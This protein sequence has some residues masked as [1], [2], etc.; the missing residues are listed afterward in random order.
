MER[1]AIYLILAVLVVFAVLA[2]KWVVWKLQHII[3]SNGI[4]FGTLLVLVII[5]VLSSLIVTPIIA[6]LGA[7]IS[8]GY[9]M[10]I[11]YISKLSLPAAILLSAFI[12]GIGAHLAFRV[13]NE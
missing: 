2:Y 3:R 6:F 1:T 11:I 8:A 5:L 7:L 9:S 4:I 10:L 13:S 12:G